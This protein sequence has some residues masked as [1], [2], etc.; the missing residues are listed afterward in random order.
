MSGVLF[1]RPC[2]VRKSAEVWVVELPF[3]R[4]GNVLALVRG[5]VAGGVVRGS[6][7]TRQ[8]A[9]CLSAVL[10]SVADMFGG[11]THLVDQRVVDGSPGVGRVPD[12]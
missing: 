9:R 12:P 6:G 7:M 10:V 2:P 8:V 5:T 11:A 3:E 1:G 4:L